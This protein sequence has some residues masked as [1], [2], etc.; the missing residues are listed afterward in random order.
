MEKEG[1]GGGGGAFFWGQYEGERGRDEGVEEGEEVDMGEREGK[2]KGLEDVRIWIQQGGFCRG[3][4]LGA[5]E[6]IGK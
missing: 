5:E 1:G 2:R 4:Y 3:V 6:G